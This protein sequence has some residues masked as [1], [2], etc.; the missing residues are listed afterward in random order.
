[1]FEYFRES[2]RQYSLQPIT[3]NNKYESACFLALI[4]AYY[5]LSRFI[6]RLT[7]G[8]LHRH[9]KKKKKEKYCASSARNIDNLILGGEEEI[10]WLMNG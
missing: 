9:E 2:H 7:R 8:W 5:Y 4:S 6:S 3:A 1:M 10:K